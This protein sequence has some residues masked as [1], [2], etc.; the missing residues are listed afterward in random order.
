M[1]KIIH[2]EL[3][4]SGIVRRRLRD[5]RAVAWDPYTAGCIFIGFNV[6]VIKTSRHW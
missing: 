2:L 6:Y 3:D 4:H 1:R 5:T